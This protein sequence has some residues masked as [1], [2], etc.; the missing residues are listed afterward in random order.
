MQI[1]TI[2]TVKAIELPPQFDSSKYDIYFWFD[3]TYPGPGISNDG[4]FVKTVHQRPKSKYAEFYT[5]DI[6]NDIYWADKEHGEFSVWK[7]YVRKEAERQFKRRFGKKAPWY[8]DSYPPDNLIAAPNFYKIDGTM[9]LTEEEEQIITNLG[10]EYCLRISSLWVML[11]HYKIRPS[12]PEFIDTMLRF[13][14]IVEEEN[15]YHL[16]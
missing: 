8:F 3:E 1:I 7:F 15:L 11:E 12:S 4:R 16:Y 5:G 10:S 9:L 14:E 6:S 13:L 2:D